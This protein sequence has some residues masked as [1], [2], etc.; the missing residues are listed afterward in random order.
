MNAHRIC[1]CVGAVL[2]LAA[3]HLP[4]SAATVE[5]SAVKTGLYTSDGVWATPSYTTGVANA[6]GPETRGLVAFDVSGLPD[7][8]ISSATLSLQNPYA[9][10][11]A[12]GN[13]ELRLF[14]LPGMNWS[15][16]T[17]NTFLNLSNFDFIGGG[18]SPIWGTVFVPPVSWPGS[19]VGF[20]LP[21][22]ALTALRQAADG[23]GPYAGDFFAFGLRIAKADAEEPK[24]LQYVFGGTAGGGS[25]R[26]AV[27]VTPV[28]ETQTW[29]LIAGLGLLAWA[30]RRWGIHGRVTAT[31][32]PCLRRPLSILAALCLAVTGS[33]QAAVLSQSFSQTLKLGDNLP[34]GLDVATL[35]VDRFDPALGSLT[36]VSFRLASDFSGGATFYH[37]TLSLTFGYTPRHYLAVEVSGLDSPPELTL[38]HTLPA[39]QYVDTTPWGGSYWQP[40]SQEHY[41][42]TVVVPLGELAQYAG[43]SPFDLTVTIEDR[44][45][46]TASHPLAY[47]NDK[48]V[49]SDFVLTVDYAYTPVVPEPQSFAMLLAGSVFAA[50]TTRRRRASRRPSRPSTSCGVCR[51]ACLEGAPRRPRLTQDPFLQPSSRS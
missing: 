8:T 49:I 12:G 3:M 46:Y 14:G 9:V 45:L 10:N 27:D 43:G 1:C 47:I 44:S 4:V 38:D 16:Y 13:L 17:G 6:Y 5:L 24:P 22:H 42:Q 50:R 19:I 20:D 29:V 39:Q 21:A 35:A 36:G 11:E 32:W 30:A 7:G 40:T 41:E 15:N 28:P 26:L 34:E 37:P 33:V 25:A 23:T 31:A 48:Y 18:L 51:A 2:G